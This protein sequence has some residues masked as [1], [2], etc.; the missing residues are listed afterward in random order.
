MS[1]EVKPAHVTTIGDA[2]DAQLFSNAGP[3]AV[4]AGLFKASLLLAATPET[5]QIHNT[6]CIIETESDDA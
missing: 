3:F 5:P 4:L 6:A 2:G 1:I